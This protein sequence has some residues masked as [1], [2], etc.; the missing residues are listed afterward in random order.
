[1][2]PAE[3]SLGCRESV[4][5]KATR[6]FR[7]TE[8]ETAPRNKWVP[9]HIV[10]TFRSVR[11]AKCSHHRQTE[12]IDPLASQRIPIVLEMEVE[13]KWSTADSR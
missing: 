4:P 13:A 5:S 1:V 10:V 12:H 9:I 6:T 3:G 11:L 8:S 7:G 2:F